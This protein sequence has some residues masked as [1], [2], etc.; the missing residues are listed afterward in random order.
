MLP[1]ESRTLTNKVLSFPAVIVANAEPVR[2]EA[3]E[4]G[5]AARTLVENG[6]PRM[7]AAL[8]RM[9]TE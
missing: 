1:K 6:E 5:A 8:M 4:E 3:V 7:W 9:E 2:K